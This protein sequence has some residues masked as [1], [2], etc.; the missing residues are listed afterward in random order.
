MMCVEL[1]KNKE[2][3]EPIAGEKAFG[4]ML[5]LQNKGILNFVCGRYGNGFRFM[6]PLTTP[7]KYFET[8]AKTFVSLVKEQEKDLML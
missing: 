5:G 4:L 2:T 6:P 7:K 1:V 8:A 3:R